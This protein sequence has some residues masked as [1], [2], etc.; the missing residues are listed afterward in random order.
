MDTPVRRCR[1]FGSVKQILLRTLEEL[2][3]EKHGY[4]KVLSSFYELMDLAV[5]DPHPRTPVD[6]VLD[7]ID[8]NYTLVD[9]TVEK[10]CDEAGYSHVHLLR[11]FKRE[12]GKTI[13]DHLIE[14]R[15]SLACELLESGD[16]SVRSVAYSC[17]FADEIHFMKCFKKHFSLTPSEYRQRAREKR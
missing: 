7:L 3:G 10:L 9:Y 12:Y 17:G 8:Q 2:R 13:R 4:Y 5:F 15:L 1:H 6:T 11:L 16:I 14:K